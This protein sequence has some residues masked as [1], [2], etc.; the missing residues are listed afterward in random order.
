MGMKKQI[1]D[2]NN[3]FESGNSSIHEILE[4]DQKMTGAK[5]VIGSE[6]QCFHSSWPHNFF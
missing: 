4:K 5:K 6:N 1:F 2:Y 3:F